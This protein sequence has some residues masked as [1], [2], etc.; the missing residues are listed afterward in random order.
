MSYSELLRSI[1]EDSKLSFKELAEK[2]RQLGKTIDP[3]YISK[4]VNNKIPPP[5]DEVSSII[6]RACGKDEDMLILEGYL[7]KAPKVLIDFI[8]SIRLHSK[9]S[10][11]FNNE[12][13]EENEANIKILNSTLVNKPL[14]EFV[15]EY[16][17]ST[18]SDS[19]NG[20]P[21]NDDS[22]EPL[23]LNGSEL[24][25]SK[26]DGT[27]HKLISDFKP[28]PDEDTTQ[29]I[30]KVNTDTV[31]F[32]NYKNGDIIIAW[33]I[34]E[35]KLLV[36]VYHRLD[37]DSDYDFLYTLTPL[38]RYYAP[39][40]YNLSNTCFNIA[41][42]VD[43]NIVLDKELISNLSRCHSINNEGNEYEYRYFNYDICIIGKVDKVINKLR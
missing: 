39:G 22:M 3:S 24:I 33:D 32:L 37:N 43:Q 17:N 23:I 35:S 11:L 26:Y 38:N 30:F 9:G 2:C 28:K 41:N 1:I 18:V 27:K 16:N 10:L 5:S 29:Q 7:E 31:G 19:E 8:N 6:S 21:M 14:S 20:I 34:K 40:L 4:L 42:I 13:K 25:I 36:R 12:N 15:L